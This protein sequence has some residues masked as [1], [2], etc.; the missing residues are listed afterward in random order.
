MGI[1]LFCSSFK[2][3]KVEEMCFFISADNLSQASQWWSTRVGYR[4][5]H[6]WVCSLSCPLTLFCA[7][8]TLVRHAG[9]EPWIK[10]G[11]VYNLGMFCRS[12]AAVSVLVY[13][14]NSVTCITGTVNALQR[15]RVCCTN[16]WQFALQLCVR[17]NLS[18]PFYCQHDPNTEVSA[19]V[20]TADVS[21]AS[22]SQMWPWALP[23]SCAVRSC[24]GLGSIPA[25][26]TWASPSSSSCVYLLGL[27][28]GTHSAKPI[29]NL[30]SLL[31]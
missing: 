26:C 22:W 11:F 14:E 18:V 30:K 13:R 10:L 21:P 19:G 27:L 12:F 17:L 31:Q 6:V 4:E 29:S 9:G 2:F 8:A 5:L 3:F 23:Q 1:I 28:Q 7:C 15:L 24:A 20:A 16:C 25:C